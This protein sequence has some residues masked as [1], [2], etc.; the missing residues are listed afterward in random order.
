MP[1]A[2]E[3]GSPLWWLDRL[4]RRLDERRPDVELFGDYYDGRQPLAFATSRFRA[5]FGGLFSA[6]S[7]N[8]CAPAVDAKEERLNIE[9]FRLGDDPAG[10]KDV[11]RIWQSNAMDADSQLAHLEALIGGESYAMVWA[12][13]DGQPTITVEHPSEVIVA[14]DPGDRSRRLA[15]LKRWMDDDGWVLA[16]VY[17]PEAI[18]KFR[19]TKRWE[20]GR[21]ADPAPG[22]RAPAAERLARRLEG[23]WRGT[24]VE[25]VEREPGMRNPL[26]T[27][28]VVP[29]RNR[30]RMLTDGVSELA[31]LTPIQ[32]AINKLTSDLLIASEF[33]AFRQRWATGIEI[34]HDSNGNPVE[35]FEAAIDRLWATES[36]TSKFGEFS[37]SD[38]GN[39][40]TA[41]SALVTHFA[42]QAKI[43]FHYLERGSG[44]PP[45][46]DSIKSA[47][48][49]LIA[50]V[51]RKQRHFGEAWEEVIRL[52]LLVTGDPRADLTD[53]ETLWGDPESRTESQH[54]D[55]VTK[56]ATLG[57]PWAQLMEDLGYSPQQIERMRAMRRLEAIDGQGIDLAML[58]AGDAGAELGV[59][60]P[61]A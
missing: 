19:S 9:G 49:G 7:D 25:W 48:A 41:V 52:A 20:G 17:L 18:Y 4:A 57:V 3:R 58:G 13:A 27:V 5:A 2:L 39:Y 30:P 35:P 51:R 14:T 46:G 50:N 40:V 32:D 47:E 55:A 31:K 56:K 28:P 34:P 61:P 6:F 60:Q 8:F 16:T 12:D 37:A 21:W 59:E 10:D 15:A 45:S 1:D 38:L 33:A 36:E 24:S 11:W 29:I 26:G 44:Q 22:E 42:A 43:P 54:V 23:S 53:T